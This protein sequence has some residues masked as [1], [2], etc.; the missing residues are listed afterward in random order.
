MKVLVL[1][2]LGSQIGKISGW[3]DGYRNPHLADGLDSSTWQGLLAAIDRQNAMWVAA[4]YR[5][6]PPDHCTCSHDRR[7]IRDD[8]GGGEPIADVR[9]GQLGW[10]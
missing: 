5:I 8:D 2:M 1:H 7:R 4:T 9:A 6:S 3:C 10:T